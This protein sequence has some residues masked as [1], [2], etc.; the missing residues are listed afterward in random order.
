MGLMNKNL[1]FKGF[2]PT[3]EN[4]H[5]CYHGYQMVCVNIYMADPD[6]LPGHGPN[7]FG[8]WV[9]VSE[10]VAQITYLQS[11]I[12]TAFTNKCHRA[13]VR[14]HRSSCSGRFHTFYL[15]SNEP[16]LANTERPVLTKSNRSGLKVD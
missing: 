2:G 12:L 4:T 15:G 1:S 7:R 14:S 13:G 5:T 11:E 16:Y 8:R 3:R 6:R 10:T 9:C